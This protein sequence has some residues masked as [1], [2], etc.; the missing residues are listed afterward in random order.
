MGARDAAA[1]HVA[2]PLC[3]RRVGSVLEQITVR[4]RRR[5]VEQRA[6]RHHVGVLGAQDE[7]VEPVEVDADLVDVDAVGL[8]FSDDGPLGQ[9]RFVEDDAAG[10]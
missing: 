9:R 5:V 10:G 8:R 1:V 7:A 6:A 4:Q 3:P 2:I